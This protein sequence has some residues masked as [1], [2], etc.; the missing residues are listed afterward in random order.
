MW[1]SIESAPG[2]KVVLLYSPGWRDPEENPQGVREGFL[3]DDDTW[4]VCVWSLGP[5][6]EREVSTALPTHW[7]P[8]PQGPRKKKTHE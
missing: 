8:V 2:N 3:P 4:Q 1:K 5:D 7:R 6:P